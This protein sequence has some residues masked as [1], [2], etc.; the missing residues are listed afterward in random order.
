MKIY[1]V[2]GDN[3]NGGYYEEYTEWYEEAFASKKSAED[4][5]RKRRDDEIAK[6]EELKHKGYYDPNLNYLTNWRIM[7]FDVR[8]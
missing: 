5:I 3:L 7:E 2:I 8:E 1:M 4:F 6:N